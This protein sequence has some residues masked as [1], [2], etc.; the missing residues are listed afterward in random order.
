MKIISI[1]EALAVAGG[2][3]VEFTLQRKINTD[4]ISPACIAK[5]LELVPLVVT[6]QITE[7]QGEAQALSACTY[8]EFDLFDDKLEQAFPF[9]IKFI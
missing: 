7:E 1:N 6:N 9:S 5:M 4:N 2:N 8:K 3:T